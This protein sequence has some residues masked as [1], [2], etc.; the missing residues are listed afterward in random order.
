MA[1]AKKKCEICDKEVTQV[2]LDRGNGFVSRKKKSYH[3]NCMSDENLK[4]RKNKW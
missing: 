3:V 2:Q 1:K 4:R